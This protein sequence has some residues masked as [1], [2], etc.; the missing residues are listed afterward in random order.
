M[1][2]CVNVNNPQS[3]PSDVLARLNAAIDDVA[4]Q[5]GWS[6]KRVAAEAGIDV[7]TLNALRWGKTTNPSDRTAWSLDRIL[8]FERGKGVQRILEGKRPVRV[9]AAEPEDATDA[10]I[11]EINAKKHLTD[12]Q[13]QMFIAMLVRQRELLMEQVD[14]ADRQQRDSA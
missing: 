10:A 6:Y 13:K 8:G 2:V 11:R 3:V 4:Q 7:M 9:K 5:P 1:P 14:E 12:R